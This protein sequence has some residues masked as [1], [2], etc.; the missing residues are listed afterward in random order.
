MLRNNFSNLTKFKTLLC[1][2]PQGF[3]LPFLDDSMFRLDSRFALLKAAEISVVLCPCFRSLGIPSVGSP[4][5]DV[6][7]IFFVADLVQP[8]VLLLDLPGYGSSH[9]QQV[10]VDGANR[11]HVLQYLVLSRVVG[12]SLDMSSLTEC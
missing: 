4:N 2:V 10:R 3:E 5:V 12:D 8:L 6:S 7:D 11:L 9:H 1:K